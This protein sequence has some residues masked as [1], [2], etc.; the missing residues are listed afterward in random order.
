M[1]NIVRLSEVHEA[2]ALAVSLLL[3]LAAAGVSSRFTTPQIKGWYAALR[4]PSWTPPNWLFGPV[5]LM[6]Y[7]GMA[8]SAWL[9]WREQ[10]LSGAAFPLLMFAVQLVLNMAWSGL[11][12]RLHHPGAAFVEIMLL[13]LAI[14][15][16]ILMFWP[17]NALAGWLMVPYVLW[18]TF[19]SALNFRIWR[20]NT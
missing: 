7:L 17:I 20:M 15:V 16:T 4:K 3:C 18:V 11:F 8:V 19:A 1:G 12:F 2:A 6:L 9:I 10:G 14:A 5:W 13:W